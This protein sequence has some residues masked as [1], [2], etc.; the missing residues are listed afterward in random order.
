MAFIVILKFFHFLSLFLAGGA[1]V[2]NV[3]IGK[4]HQKAKEVPSAVVQRSM[5]KLA[6]IGLVTY[7]ACC[8]G[9]AMGHR[10][11]SRLSNL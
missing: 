2:A 11:W 7:W 9:A 10:N 8:D 4:E 3:L 5:M 6:R 1:G